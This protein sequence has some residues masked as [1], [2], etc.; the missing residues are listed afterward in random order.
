MYRGFEGCYSSVAKHHG[1]GGKF[2]VA[3]YRD[4]LLASCFCFLSFG[5]VAKKM[6]VSLDSGSQLVGQI[7]FIT[8]L[9]PIVVKVKSLTWQV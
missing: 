7:C 3:K 2:L 8:S 1:N 5:E 4:V 6:L 9:V